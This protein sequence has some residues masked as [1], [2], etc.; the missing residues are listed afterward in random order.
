VQRQLADLEGGGEGGDGDASTAGSGAAAALAKAQETVSEVVGQ[1]KD[2][3]AAVVDRAGG[4]LKDQLG[5]ISS[6]LKA[7]GAGGSEL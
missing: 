3:A 6:S 7:G 4:F 2:A 5:R 1:A